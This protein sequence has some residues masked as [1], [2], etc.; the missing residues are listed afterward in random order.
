VLK[1]YEQGY[2]CDATRQDTVPVVLFKQDASRNSIL[3]PFFI[4]SVLVVSCY[5]TTLISNKLTYFVQ[6]MKEQL[7][8]PSSTE[9][10]VSVCVLKKNSTGYYN[11][12]T[13]LLMKFADSD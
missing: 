3:E 8:F 4:A 2:F 7:T 6:F 9:F 1:W 10:W 11:T 12:V 5:P 13:A